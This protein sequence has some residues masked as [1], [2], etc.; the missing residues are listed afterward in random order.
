MYVCPVRWPLKTYPQWCILNVRLQVTSNDISYGDSESVLN[1]AAR[2]VCSA[3][4]YD[5]VTPL[6]RDLHWL[7]APERI[8]YRLAVLA[9]RCQHVL[10]PS[11]LST[12]LQRVVDLDS[13]RRLRSAVCVNDGTG[14]A[15]DAH[16]TIS[17]CA[18]P[19]AAALS[20][21]DYH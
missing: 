13:R 3:R 8:A 6:L 7:R 11:Y 4:K 9:F 18:F 5:H 17:N 19:V 14:S 10:A 16:S 21:T 20:G 12:E 15:Q 1:A 2:F